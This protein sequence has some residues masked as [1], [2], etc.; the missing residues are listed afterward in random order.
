MRVVSVDLAHTSY[1]NLGI[2]LLDEVKDHF[3]V[4]TLTSS[5]LRLTGSPSAADLATQLAA[6]CHRQ[7]VEM[8][9]LDGPQAWEH[10]ANG[11]EHSRVCERQ[12]NSPGKTGLPGHAKPANYLPF[13]AFSVA[14]FQALVDRGFELWPGGIGSRLVVETFPWSAWRQ[15]GLPP[16]PSKAK[17]RREHLQQAVTSLRQL[18]P[19]YIPQC[20]SHDEVQALVSGLAGVPIARGAV[21]GYAA[22]GIAPSLL[23]GTWRE[24]FIINPT[25]EALRLGW[26]AVDASEAAS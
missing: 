13:I 18:F 8:L 3:E 4:R 11:L 10:P 19:I 16:L 15:L 1:A 25:R 9:L 17:T 20:L 6:F 22:A 26:A 24:G 7:S 23:E 14:V 12:L 21:G 2:V 5:D